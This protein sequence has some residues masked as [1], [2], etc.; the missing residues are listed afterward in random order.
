MTPGSSAGRRPIGVPRDSL[1]GGTTRTRVPRLAFLSLSGCGGCIESLLADDEVLGTLGTR[2]LV[3]RVP[4]AAPHEH[5]GAWDIVVV[6][7]AVATE[8]DREGLE[9]VRENASCL[10]ALGTCA[11]EGGPSAGMRAAS[12]AV[13]IDFV[14][15]GCPVFSRPALHLLRTLIDGREPLPA[16]CVVCDECRLRG[17]ECVRRGHAGSCLGSSTEAGCGALCLAFDRECWRCTRRAT[18]GEGGAEGR[19]LQASPSPLRRESPR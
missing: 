4:Q 11:V 14:V 17:Q 5:R 1:R 10:V 8:R 15:G 6:E 19:P 7:G 18:G 13:K 12:T 2:A 16:D 3:M 9:R